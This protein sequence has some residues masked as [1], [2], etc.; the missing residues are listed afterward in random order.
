M[1]KNSHLRLLMTVAG[2][3]RLGPASEETRDSSW[4]VPGEVSAD[5]LKDTLHYINQ[6]EFNPPTFEEGVLAE[7]QLRRKTVPRKKAA[8]DDDDEG[9]VDFLD[10]EMLFPAGGPT[11]RKAIDDPAKPK[12]TRRRRKQKDEDP[13][14]PDEKA[15][16]RREREREK[17][18]KVK[19]AL[20]VKEGDDEFDSEE[21]EAFF[22][23][24]REIKA[25]A[26]RLARSAAAGSAS[27]AAGTA[28]KRKKRKSDVFSEESDEDDNDNDVLKRVLSSQDGGDSDTDDTTVDVS[29]GEARKKRRVSVKSK[30]IMDDNEGRDASGEE[31]VAMT[32]L[33][34]AAVASPGGD[35][36]EDEEVPVPVRRPRVRGGFVIDSDDDE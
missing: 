27:D 34:K 14:A 35:D 7:N 23:R 1:F 28:A 10:D 29:D 5:L 30:N 22:A 17:A 4:V 33:D 19:S 36:E 20:Y 26:E 11:A 3:Q 6:A 15:R 16:K 18:R 12:K 9:G 21:D 25:R 13:E 8:F 2:F 32:A 31:D 24:E